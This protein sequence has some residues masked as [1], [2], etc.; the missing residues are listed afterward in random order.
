VKP[1]SLNT[2]TGATGGSLSSLTPLDRQ[3]F[4]RLQL[5]Q[6]QLT[7]NVQHAAG[8]NPKAFRWVPFLIL[9]P[10]IWT[11]PARSMVRNDFVSK[12]LLKGILDGN[13]WGQ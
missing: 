9:V 3:M 6:G 8:L 1:A 12:P 11:H 4:K 7:R 13:L 10:Q 2:A 5:L